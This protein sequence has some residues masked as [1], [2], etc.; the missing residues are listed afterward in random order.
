MKFNIMNYRSTNTKGYAKQEHNPQ[1]RQH[2]QLGGS[3]SNSNFFPGGGSGGFVGPAGLGGGAGGR[4][5]NDFE[6]F[7]RL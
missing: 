3:K 2:P 5:N 1:H 4:Y 7:K 6:H